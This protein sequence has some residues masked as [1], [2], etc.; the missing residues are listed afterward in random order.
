MGSPATDATSEQCLRHDPGK[1]YHWAFAVSPHQ[2]GSGLLERSSLLTAV[3]LAHAEPAPSSHG[4]V[5]RPPAPPET[6]RRDPASS[7][8]VE[9]HGLPVSN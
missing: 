4:L 5:L 1:G 8:G 2:G 7:R 3:Q 9:S 6:P